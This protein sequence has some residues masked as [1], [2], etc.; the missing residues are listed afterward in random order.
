MTTDY[1]DTFT[2]GVRETLESDQPAA[3][4]AETIQKALNAVAMSIKADLEAPAGGADIATALKAALGPISDQIA[5][6]NA[7]LNM[8]QQAIVMP[9]QKSIAVPSVAQVLP[10]QDQLPVSPITGQP[11]TLTAQI[12]RSVGI[13]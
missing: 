10:Q 6:L 3:Q 8:P 4:K 1:L 7:R 12:R 5:Q 2:E 11:S 13:Q 9:T